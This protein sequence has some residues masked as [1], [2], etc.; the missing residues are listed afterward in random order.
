MSLYAIFHIKYMCV[1]LQIFTYPS[2]NYMAANSCELTTYYFHSSVFFA[3]WVAQTHAH[4][5]VIRSCVFIYVTCMA[6]AL[7]RLYAEHTYEGMCVYFMEI[8]ML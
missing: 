8:Y 5:H 7:Q 4:T 2:E 6:Q 3:V 1:S